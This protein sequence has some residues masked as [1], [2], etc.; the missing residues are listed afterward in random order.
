[1]NDI[2]KHAAVLSG[3][4]TVTQTLLWAKIQARL[5]LSADFEAKSQLEKSFEQLYFHILCFLSA[6]I[7]FMKKG[8]GG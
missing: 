6:T 3:I 2:D 5:Y 4:D 1:M 8:K 7:R